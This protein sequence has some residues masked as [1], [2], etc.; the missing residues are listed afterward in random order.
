MAPPQAALALRVM[1]PKKHTP[2]ISTTLKADTPKRML[3]SQLLHFS[4]IKSVSHSA[5]DCVLGSALGCVVLSLRSAGLSGRPNNALP[6][7]SLN[8]AFGWPAHCVGRPLAR[9]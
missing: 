1:E 3:V 8:A 9:R 4:L 7:K 5:L 6:D 2:R